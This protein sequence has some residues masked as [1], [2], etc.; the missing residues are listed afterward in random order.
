MS[1]STGFRVTEYNRDEK[2]ADEVVFALKSFPMNPFVTPDIM[3]H[4]IRC[5]HAARD[6]VMKS[7]KLAAA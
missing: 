2:D 3:K 7:R 6:E 5:V 4:T 1:F